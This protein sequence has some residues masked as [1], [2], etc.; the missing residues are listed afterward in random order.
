MLISIEGQ[1]QDEMQASK[2]D[3]SVPQCSQLPPKNTRKGEM[4]QM[5]DLLANIF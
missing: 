1:E 3:K 2:E 4:P 5:I